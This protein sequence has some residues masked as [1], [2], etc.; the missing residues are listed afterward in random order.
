MSQVSLFTDEDVYGNAAVALRAAGFDAISVPE[1][2][3][4]SHSDESHLE[5]AARNGRVMVSFNVRDVAALHAAWLRAG[6]SHA[7]VVVSKRRPLGDFIR[8]LIRLG[9]TLDGDEMKNR[10]EFLSDW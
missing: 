10:L 6:R 2:G 4:L 5:W 9:Q 3:R 7:G 8:R 1:A